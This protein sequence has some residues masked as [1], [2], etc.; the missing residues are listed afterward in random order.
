M[1]KIAAVIALVVACLPVFAEVPVV[2]GIV[3]PKRPVADAIGDAMNFL[4]KADGAYVPGKTDGE[5][6]GYFT[7]AYVNEDGSRSD[8]EVAFPG[9]QHGYFIHTFLLY[10][11]QTGDAQWLQ[12]ARDL[13]DW[14]LKHLSPADATYANIPWSTFSEGKPGGS[15]DKESTEP[16]KAA[17]IGIAFIELFEATKDQKYLDASTAIAQTLV[18]NQKEDGSWPFR[19]MA[20]DGKV[21][22]ELGGA[23]VSYV[24]LF[25]EL[26]RHHPSGDFKS[27]HEKALKLMIERNI[28]KDLW[29]TYHED[30]GNK[31]PDAYSAEP[32]CFTAAYLFR[33]G[34]E[35]PEYIE[36][37]KRVIAR[38]EGKLVH[39]SGHPAAPAPAVSEQ[40]GF[41]HM[42]PGHT[43]RYCMALAQLYAAT[44]DK[45]A[46]DKAVS[47]INALTYMQSDAGLFRTFFQLLN[48]RHPEKKRPNWYSQHLYTVCHVL[49]ATALLPELQAT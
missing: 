47:G 6:A 44:G 38:M 23:P 1:K 33:H 40:A 4:R 27:A 18:K 3:Q 10:H 9:R 41:E 12:R 42:M 13:S 2:D 49:E 8:R 14:N 24:Q 5:L 7:S 48:D 25:E 19:V 32:M 34:K 43:A 20:Q 17:F 22:Q 16:D 30:V 45:Q 29:G 21:V 31:K 11:K 36:M 37:G 39:T 26:Q 35:H 28:E 15:A 46:H